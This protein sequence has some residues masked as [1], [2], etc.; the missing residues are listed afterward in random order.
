MIIIRI[1]IRFNSL[2]RSNPFNKG[3]RTKSRR[4]GGETCPAA[5]L[6]CMQKVCLAGSQPSGAPASNYT[7]QIHTGDAQR[8]GRKTMI[9][10]AERENFERQ[11]D[12]GGQNDPQH[13]GDQTD[14]GLKIGAVLQIF[15]TVQHADVEMDV[16]VGKEYFLK[17]YAQQDRRDGR[18][19]QK[20]KAERHQKEHG[21]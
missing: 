2:R 13:N 8:D 20:Q 10:G 6:P 3:D 18:P 7:P 19:G 17:A 16:I 11:C 9:D 12:G 21:A 5:A 1:R 15:H 14:H 4:R